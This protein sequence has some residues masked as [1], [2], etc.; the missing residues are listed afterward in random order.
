MLGVDIEDISRFENKDRVSDKKF[1]ERIFTASELD[2]CYSYKTYAEHLCARFCAKE[3]VIK[4]LSP[5]GIKLLKY[6]TIEVYHGEFN[7]AKVR[8]LT[9]EYDDIKIDISLSHD[10]T[11]AIAVAMVD[12]SIKCKYTYKP[13]CMGDEG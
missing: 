13:C 3:A 6:N 1:L 7:E 4:V 10:S 8:L 11:K 12:N 5:L 9:P 2:Y